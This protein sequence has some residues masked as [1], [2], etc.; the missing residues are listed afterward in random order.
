MPSDTPALTVIDPK[1]AAL[2]AIRALNVPA[3]KRQINEE[4]AAMKKGL[5]EDDF[6][7]SM[8]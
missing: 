2:A 3:F 6:N 1:N 7:V 5:I 8:S 4:I